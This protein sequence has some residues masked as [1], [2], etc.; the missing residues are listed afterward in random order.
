MDFDGRPEG[1]D[2]QQTGSEQQCSCG[3]VREREGKG[4]PCSQSGENYRGNT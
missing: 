1:Q 2:K 3:H 4:D